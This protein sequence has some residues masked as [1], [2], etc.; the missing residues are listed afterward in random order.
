ML[1]Y[2]NHPSFDTVSPSKDNQKGCRLVDEKFITLNEGQVNFQPNASAY[3][4][5][6]VAWNVCMVDITETLREIVPNLL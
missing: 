6:E 1:S 5:K 4:L 2:G 3:Q